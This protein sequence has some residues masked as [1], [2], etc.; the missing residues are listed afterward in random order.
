[1]PYTSFVQLHVQIKTSGWLVEI[2][3]WRVVWR[4]A[5]TE[6][7]ALSV[8]TRGILMMPWLPADNLVSV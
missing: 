7:G 3:T 2:I 5:T 1:M 8:M 4:C 6:P